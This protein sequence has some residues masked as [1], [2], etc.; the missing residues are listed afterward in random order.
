MSNHMDHLNAICDMKDR[1]IEWT[2]EE[3]GKGKEAIDTKE[4]GEVIDIIKDLYQAE[5]YCWKP[6]PPSRIF[7]VMRNPR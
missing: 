7:G 2:K 4:M 3:L 6:S 5:A 1:F